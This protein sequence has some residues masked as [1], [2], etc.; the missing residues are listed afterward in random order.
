MEHK[1]VSFSAKDLIRVLKACRE[2][3]VAELKIGDISVKF[4][5]D[6]TTEPVNLGT[7]PPKLSDDEFH[8][9]ALNNNVRENLTAAEDRLA[10]LQIDNPAEYERLVLERELEDSGKSAEIAEH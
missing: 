3:R 10:L 5:N 6:D 9:A 7:L 2:S 4:G 1:V 8:K